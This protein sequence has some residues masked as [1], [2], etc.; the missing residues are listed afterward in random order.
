MMPS[1]KKIGVFVIFAMIGIGGLIQQAPLIE[2]PPSPNPSPLGDFSFTLL[3]FLLSF[4]YFVLVFLIGL[5]YTIPFWLIITGDFI[6]LY[7]L[8]CLTVSGFVRYKHRF[9]ILH[10]AI[11]FGA[12]FLLIFL[13]LFYPR[14]PHISVDD[15][16]D[17]LGIEL[18]MSLYFFLLFCMGFLV[19]DALKK[20][21]I[22]SL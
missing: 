4:P 22:T 8:A 6:Y 18:I 21:N 11:T 3:N 2:S 13:I 17:Y 12:P 7:F 5:V 16:L 14:A 1:R 20:R 15:L 9:S 10:W 19:L